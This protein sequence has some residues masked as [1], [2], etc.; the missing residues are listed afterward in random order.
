MPGYEKPPQPPFELNQTPEQVMQVTH[1]G[2][3]KSKASLDLLA[4]KPMTEW[5]FAGFV[6]PFAEDENNTVLESTLV[7]IYGYVSKEKELRDAS[8]AAIQL[9]NEHEREVFTRPDLFNGIDAVYKQCQDGSIVLDA[10]E[11]HYLDQVH[12]K[13]RRNAVHIEG[14]TKEQY[15]AL[16][17]RI[18]QL[19]KEC[20]RNVQ[21]DAE[22]LWFEEAELNGVSEE[23]LASRERDADN[24]MFVGL[25][26]NDIYVVSR[27][28]TEESTRRRM[29]IAYENKCP[30]N[31][32]LFEELVNCRARVANLLG[33]ASYAEYTIQGRM[34]TLPQVMELLLS[35]NTMKQ[36]ADKADSERA[37][38]MEAKKQFLI[39]QGKPEDEIDPRIHIWDHNFYSHVVR[40]ERFDID[41]KAVSEYFPLNHTLAGMLKIFEQIFG[42]HFEPVT[43]GA[44]VWDKSVI[45]SAVWNEEALGG[46][47][48]GYVYFDLFERP[49]KF[50]SNCNA[51]IAPGF[52][53]GKRFYPGIVLLAS[54][55]PVAPIL[56]RHRQVITLFHE[57]GHTIHYLVGKTRFA[58]TY[59]TSTSHD[60]VEIPS[61]ML[62]Y[63]CWNPSIL[64]SLSRHYAYTSDEEKEAY[65]KSHEKLP[66]EKPPIDLF[67]RLNAAK[68]VNEA[69]GMQTQLHFTLYDLTV[70]GST[71]VEDLSA[72]YNRM[73]R[74]IT[75]RVGPESH[76]GDD[77][78]G[79]GQASF[80]H[81]FKNYAA[82]YYVYF[83][84]NAY[85]AIMFNTRFQ[86]NPLDEAEGRRYRDIVLGK[87]GGLP[88]L[89]LLKEFV[90][91][92]LDTSKIFSV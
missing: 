63:W 62:E 65:L 46:E 43:S 35:D 58:S 25:K 6:L 64:H 81:F 49:G 48:L 91:G 23:Y 77:H 66:A 32:A 75:T 34:L 20:L 51:Y 67:E 28:A 19:S 74:E 50:N 55:S 14:E 15:Q 52:T 42:L 70:H 85:S 78:W 26:K 56:I 9:W 33:Y 89:P 1:D 76:G 41:D 31:V 90:G 83:L 7:Q 88:Q 22:G 84:G 39:K 2:I 3:A 57:L 40:K 21:E 16:Q 18:D 4:A 24:K 53:E 72:L 37:I 36:V 87:G 29:Y 61:K 13:F 60:F 92:E 5:T 80:Q 86:N 45:V 12:L 38:L 30:Q 10:E 17:K 44:W 73:R 8:R 68:E 27:F 71:P 59:G 47:F 82:G 54:F 69:C 79:F 11:R